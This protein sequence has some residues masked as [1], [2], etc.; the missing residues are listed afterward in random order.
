[1]LFSYGEEGGVLKSISVRCIIKPW[2]HGGF[3]KGCGGIFLTE[4]LLE[5]CFPRG[6][7]QGQYFPIKR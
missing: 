6:I 7:F 2:K 4:R 5:I 3:Y 1:M